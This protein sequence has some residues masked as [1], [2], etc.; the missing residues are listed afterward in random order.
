MH[1]L[2]KTVTELHALLINFEKGL[3]YKAP[4]PQVFTIQKGRDNKPKPQANKKVKGKGK[5]DKNKQVVPYQPKPKPNPLKRK[6]N[7]NKDKACHH[8]HVVGHWKRNCPLYIE[9][10]RANKKKSEPSAAVS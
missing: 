5:A 4:T 1:C 2:G 9:E 8:F 3:K 6:E 10:L 7:P